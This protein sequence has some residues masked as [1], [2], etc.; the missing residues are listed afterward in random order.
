MAVLR[1]QARNEVPDMQEKKNSLL[2][3]ADEQ[4]KLPAPEPRVLDE[5][6]EQLLAWVIAP[7]S[8]RVP[9]T[10]TAYSELYDISLATLKRW[11]N[12]PHFR[13]AYEK[14]VKEHIASPE[15][16]QFATDYA[17]DMAYGGSLSP[18]EAIKWANHYADLAGLKK[19][20]PIVTKSAAEAIADL[21]D[22][23]L[24]ALL[25]EAAAT[26]SKRRSSS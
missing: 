13:A 2:R 23:E 18:A 10:L 11:R 15:R 4:A 6:Q 3:L 7:E 1:D 25:F 24:D 14:Y 8:Q 5:R 17:Y 20:E 16:I 22:E 21:S 12:L 19:I 26:E 9:P